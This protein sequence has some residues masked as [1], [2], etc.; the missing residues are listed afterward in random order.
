M[1]SKSILANVI[2]GQRLDELGEILNIVWMVIM[3]IMII[4]SQIGYMMVE[5]GSIKVTNC[6]DFLLKNFI[7][8]AVS[9]LTF[10]LVGYGFARNAEGGLMGQNNFVGLGYEYQDFA[11]W[12]YYYSLCVTMASIATGSIAERTS[13]DTYFFYTFLTSSL[14]FPLA[15]AWC[16]EDGWLQSIGF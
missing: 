2:I 6:T 16:W 5:T 1:A 13:M 7:V 4:L 14:I 10:F 11:K 12:L 8:M 15:L 3:S 9:S